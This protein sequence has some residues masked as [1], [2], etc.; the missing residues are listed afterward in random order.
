MKP[1]RGELWLVDLGFTEGDEMRKQRPAVVVSSDAIGVLDLRVVVPVTGWQERFAARE[2]MATLN[3]DAENNL[4]KTSTADAFQVR[5][6]ALSR[7]VR[8]IGKLSE[9]DMRGVSMAIEA[10]FDM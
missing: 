4:A 10:V 6:I 3:P 2:W 8:R 9:A 7:F 5:S 1:N